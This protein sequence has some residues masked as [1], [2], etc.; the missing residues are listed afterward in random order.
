MVTL[1]DVAQKTGVT[2]ATVSNVI[3][4]KGAVGEATRQR[5]LQAIEELGYRPNLMARGLVEGK[6]FT[7]ALMVEN[8]A[9]PFYGEIALEIERDAQARDYHLLLYNASEGP[10]V[11]KHQLD[12]LLGGFVDGIIVIA[13]MNANQALSVHRQGRPI[14]LCNWQDYGSLPDVPSVDIDFHQAGYL[15]G[16]HLLELGHRHVAAVVSG[17]AVT[18]TVWHTR[19]LEGFRQALLEAGVGLSEAQIAF[20]NGTIE[21]GYSATRML[22]EGA[23]PPTGLFAT[24]DMMAIGALEAAKDVGL[25]VPEA[26]SI[27][28]LDD[29]VLGAHVRPSLTTVALS[30]GPFT[31][32]IMTLLMRQIERQPLGEQHVW[33]TPYLI[34]RQST[35]APQGER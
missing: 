27:V 8:I 22:L 7:L 10:N 16:Q 19:R 12:R 6:S 25:A 2:A 4:N 13:G 21:T 1:H 14:V 23:K 11:S 20:G 24:N 33:V 9:N 15:A 32:A 5:V 31:Q 18:R 34:R 28:G 35:A 17:D 3:R 29:V 30:K 26:L